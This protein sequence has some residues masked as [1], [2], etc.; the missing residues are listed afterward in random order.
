M[1]KEERQEAR[2]NS[3]VND[4]I[5][6][7]DKAAKKGVIKKNTAARKKTRLMKKLNSK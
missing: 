7:I 4:A 5:K 3:L 2:Y 6:K 1:I